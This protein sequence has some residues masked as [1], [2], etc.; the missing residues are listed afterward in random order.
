MTSTRGNG[1]NLVC[2]NH[3]M[4][5]QENTH[6]YDFSTWELGEDALSDVEVA[7]C[8]LLEQ[9]SNDKS[10]PESD[11]YTKLHEAVLDLVRGQ[12]GYAFGEHRAGTWRI[13][14][15]KDAAIRW[16]SE[17]DQPDEVQSIML[18]P[19]QI[20]PLLMGS[21]SEHVGQFPPSEDSILRAELGSDDDFDWE[22]NWLQAEAAAKEWHKAAQASLN[23]LYALKKERGERLAEQGQGYSPQE[24][25]G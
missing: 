11:D 10:G 16:F 3:A 25:H 12:L 4:N 7:V 22:E 24:D 19:R 14:L 5:D 20:I 9:A 18:K 2:E 15:T 1:S 6:P 8:D 21:L 17:I 13:D 23:G